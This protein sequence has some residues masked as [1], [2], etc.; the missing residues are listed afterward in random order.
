MPAKSR[1]K[2]VVDAWA[3]LALLQKEEPA[4]TRVKAVI[5]TAQG[6]QCEL[7]ASLINIGEVYYS[8]GRSKGI[9]EA[10]SVLEDIEQLPLNIIPADRAAVIHAATLKAT[11]RLSYADAFAMAAALAIDAAPVHPDVTDDFDGE[12]RPRSGTASRDLGADEFLP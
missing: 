8:V 11:H 2:K 6:G 1:P 9:S 3:L 10:N 7:F 12:L 5:D 4:A